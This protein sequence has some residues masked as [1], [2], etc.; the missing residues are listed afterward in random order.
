MKTKIVSLTAILAVAA[1]AIGLAQA[2]GFG[3]YFA[4]IL[5]NGTVATSSGVAAAARTAAGRYEITFNRSIAGCATLVSVTGAVP[6]W[7]V[8]RRKP[9]TADVLLVSTFS[10][11]G[12]AT[13]LPFHLMISCNS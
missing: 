7:G 3:S 10:R 6:A 12:A 2:S 8:G 9:G 4:V 11:T 1:T 5:S 13:D